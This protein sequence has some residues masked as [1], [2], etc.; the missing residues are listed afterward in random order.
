M[1]EDELTLESCWLV[2]ENSWRGVNSIDDFVECM[3]L[4]FAEPCIPACSFNFPDLNYALCSVVML[5]SAFFAFV[6][7][8][9][10]LGCL[11]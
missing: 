9:Q 11:S 7:L 10:T 3:L 8:T 1:P 4:I 6:V 5:S 2:F